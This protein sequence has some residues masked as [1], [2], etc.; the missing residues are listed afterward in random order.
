MVGLPG[1]EHA[2]LNATRYKPGKASIRVV[3]LARLPL[4]RRRVA[5]RA[6]AH[7]GRQHREKRPIARPVQRGHDHAAIAL[8]HRYGS[9]DA[10][11][12]QIAFVGAWSTETTAHTE[13]EI[14]AVQQSAF[15]GSRGGREQVGAGYGK[16]ESKARMR[17][18]GMGRY[19]PTNEAIRLSQSTR[20]AE[21]ERHEMLPDPLGKFVTTDAPRC[22]SKDDTFRVVNSGVEL[23]PVQHQKYFERRV[24]DALVA[25]DKRMVPNKREPERRRLVN[26]RWIQLSVVKCRAGLGKCGLKCP[27]IAYRRRPAAHYQHAAVEV[28]YLSER[29]MPRCHGRTGHAS[30]RYSSA[31]FSITC[32]AAAS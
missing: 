32:A 22:N 17:C 9:R 26:E 28:E 11:R 4:E 30:R 13:C 12:G 19:E 2:P 5:V 23:M 6:N 15:L 25:I 29:K 1:R 31:F 21:L 27:K 24:A 18:L 10:K 14:H 16:Q 20:S 7:A 8:E 3:E